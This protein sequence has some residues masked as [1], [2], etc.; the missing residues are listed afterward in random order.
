MTREG[1]DYS[2]GRPGP[3]ALVKAGKTFAVRYVCDPPSA[4]N[5]S[6][7]EIRALSAAG[8]DVVTN[9]EG[10]SQGFMLGG[11]H[12]GVAAAKVGLA[13][14]RACGMPDGRPIY[15]SVD[16][17]PTYDQ[18]A[19]PVKAFLHGA[20]VVLGPAQVGIYGGI[21]PVTWAHQDGVAAWLWQ[22][23]A[24]S[25]GQWYPHAHI[26]QYSNGHTLDGAAVDY[27]RATVP[28]FGQWRAKGDAMALDADAKQYF[29]DRFAALHRDLVVAIH[30]GDP[31]EAGRNSLDSLAAELAALKQQ[32]PNLASG[33]VPAYP[34]GSLNVT[35]AGTLTGTATPE[36][37]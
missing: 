19:G 34:P 4:K 8:I 21:Y 10:T 23:Y 25:G 28:D 36:G 33:T 35:V 3:A 31:P 30:G 16:F 14:A 32:V 37:G 13:Q 29:D 12:A 27:D 15:F 24:W 18:Y 2:F 17:N 9:Y 6:P 5:M 26:Q 11:A 7:N 22:T 20:G 1:V